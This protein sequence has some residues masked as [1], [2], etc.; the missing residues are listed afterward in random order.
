MRLAIVALVALAAVLVMPAAALAKEGPL[1]LAL[2]PVGQPGPYFDLTMKPGE[3]RTFAV[4]IANDGDTVVAAATYA[5]DVYTIIN[6]GFGGRLRDEPQTGATAWIDYPADVLQ[7]APGDATDRSFSVAVPDSARPGEYISSLVLENDQPILDTAAVGLN[8]I[9]RQAVAVVVTVPGSRSPGLAIGAAAHKIAAGRSIVQVAVENTGN[10]RLKPVVGF[11]LVD[12][13]GTQISHA[14]VQMDTFYAHTDAFVEVPLATLL[15]PGTYTVGLTLDD[16]AS[17]AGTRAE[18][19]VLIVEAPAEA[20]DGAGVVPG[21]I[22]VLQGGGTS[23]AMLV[24][25]LVA[26]A[27]FCIGAAWLVHRRRRGRDT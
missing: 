7:L 26:G 14:T 4:T 19:I 21:L 12:P 22:E 11:T 17:R 18:A 13:T 20:A 25:V 9:V 5:A 1:R 8:Q 27:L 15:T 24:V 3:T 6:G 10:I 23:L 16:A 2:L